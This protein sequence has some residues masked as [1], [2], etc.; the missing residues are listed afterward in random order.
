MTNLNSPAYP[1][2]DNGSGR[3][4]EESN[5]VSICKLLSPDQTFGKLHKHFCDN[6]MRDFLQQLHAQFQVRGSCL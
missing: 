4:D 6:F 1:E 3:S 5:N 2:S